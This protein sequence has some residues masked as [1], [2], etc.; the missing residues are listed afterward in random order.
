M[1]HSMQAW[2]LHKHMLKWKSCNS[3]VHD[4][5]QETKSLR[6]GFGIVGDGQSGA[7]RGGGDRG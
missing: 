2:F 4:S 1:I 7:T 6:T 3:R 5:G